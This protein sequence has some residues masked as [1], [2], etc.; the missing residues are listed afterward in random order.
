MRQR[1]AVRLK[2][3]SIREVAQHARVSRATVSRVMSGAEVA[4]AAVTRERVLRAAE[5]LGYF[6]NAVARGLAGKPMNTVGVVLAYKLPSVTS[7]PF[8][9]PVLDGILAQ[10]KNRR[11]KMVLF[12]EDGWNEALDNVPTYCDGHCDGLILVIPRSDSALPEE[13]LSRRVPLVVLGEHRDDPHI[14]TVDA[15]NTGMAYSAVRCLVLEGHRRIAMLGGNRE[16]SSNSQRLE[17]YRRALTEAG[18]EVDESLI[19]P[20]E[21]WEWSG[22]ERTET[23]LR[24][25]RSRRPTALFCSNGRIAVG[26]LQAIQAAGLRVP[27]DMSLTAVCETPEIATALFPLTAAQARLR[28]IGERAVTELLAQTLGHQQ[29]GAKVLVPGDMFVRQSVAPPTV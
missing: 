22:Q 10:S 13:L 7:D 4:I 11:Q 27:E 3:V 8:L 12:A 19:L 25:P 26:A 15:D 29:P 6:P 9:G 5:D 18:I 2:P 17:G 1:T 24:I 20:G 14:T 21:Y 23:I 28:Q 16:F